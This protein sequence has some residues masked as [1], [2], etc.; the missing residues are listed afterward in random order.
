MAQTT[1]QQLIAKAGK[2]HSAGKYPQAEKIYRQ[3]L[4]ANPNDLTLLRIL[5]ML[6][7]DRRNLKAAIEWFMVAKQISG[8]DPVILA[9]LALTL[10]QAG[11]GDKAME[12]AA[13]AQN[14]KPNDMTIAIFYAKM[15]LARGLATEAGIAIEQAIDTDPEN[16]E[17][18]KLLSMA[19]N[20]SG[21]LPVPLKFAT[22]LISLQEHEAQPHAT[23]ATAH[24][25]NGNFKEAFA[26]YE[27]ALAF[28]PSLE[29]AIA[30]MAEVLVSLGKTQEAEKFLLDSPN[31]NSVLV[32]LAKVRIARKLE[33]PNRA[34]SAI[35][36][37]LSPSLSPYHQS[38]LLMHKGRVLD[39]LER[40]DEAWSCWKEANKLHGGKFDLHSHIK[41]VNSII[42]TPSTD[43]GL[44]NSKQPLFIIGMYRSG[45]TLLEQILG[46]H[47]QIDAAGEV[48]QMLRFANESPYPKC[49][50]EPNKNWPQQYLDRLRSDNT[51]CTD[52]LPSNYLHVGL[53][54]R[55]FPKAII[56]HTT[57]NPLDTCV[58]CYSNSFTANHAYTSDLS[59]LAGVYK[60]YQRVMEHWN[61]LL[62]NRIYE[63]SYESLV[64]DLEG[65]VRGV[66]EHID[67]KFDPACLEFYNVRRIAV[68]PSADQVRRPIY[69]SSVGRHKHFESHLG[70]LTSLQQ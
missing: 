61:T 63:V 33:K 58:S 8:N 13:K 6:E 3:L 22:K 9:E 68:T 31:S 15:C 70:E 36:S 26:S 14:A 62:P 4:K 17:A 50:S 42:E 52:K 2:F 66:L 47:P 41:F 56:I 48:D 11:K 5:G 38:N 19:V 30:G 20:S 55:L 21:T 12:I 25:L 32:A 10:D 27:R 1:G 23:L 67:V 64:E 59:D 60:Q 37:V 54:H 65:T 39:E 45:T 34:I 69:S 18:W 40:Y 46:A 29:E 24:R 16:I 57:R 28:D 51:F 44:S 35:D 43:A 53:I 49:V 7:R